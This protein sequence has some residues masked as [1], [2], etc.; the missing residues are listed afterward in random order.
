MG[1][2]TASWHHTLKLTTTNGD[3]PTVVALAPRT[4]QAV[5]VAIVGRDRGPLLSTRRD[6]A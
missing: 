3:R 5:A 1:I 2:A 4:M 6:G